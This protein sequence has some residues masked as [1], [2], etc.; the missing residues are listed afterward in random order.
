MGDDELVTL[1]NMEKRLMGEIL[2]LIEWY[3]VAAMKF[4]VLNEPNEKSKCDLMVIETC[5]VM[6]LLCDHSE[7]DS[8]EII[9]QKLQ[10]GIMH[11]I[12]MYTDVRT[13]HQERRNFYG[14]DKISWRASPLVED[15]DERIEFFQECAQAA[16]GIWE[17]DFTDNEA[18]SDWIGAFDHSLSEYHKTHEM[19]P[20]PKMEG[21][22]KR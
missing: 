19:V 21:K 18:R 10:E 3:R 8:I 9:G 15:C 13:R 6:A 11:M 17:P 2:G 5:E 7:D 12:K 4:V 22:R 16:D 14:E 20:M 1:L